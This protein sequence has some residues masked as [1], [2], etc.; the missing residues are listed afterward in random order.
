MAAKEVRAQ[1]SVTKLLDDVAWRFLGA[2][3]GVARVR[4]VKRN[5]AEVDAEPICEFSRGNSIE[6]LLSA[7]AK[8]PLGV[9]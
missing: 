1:R 3:E 6:F 4:K 7:E 2:P 9:L 5:Q 8:F